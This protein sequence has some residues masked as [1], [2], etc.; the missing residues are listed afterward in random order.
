MPDGARPSLFRCLMGLV[1]VAAPAAAQEGAGAEAEQLVLAADPFETTDP[2]AAKP[3]EAELAFIGIYERARQGAYRDTGAVATEIQ[4][5][6]APRLEI[7]FGQLGAYG[8]LQTRGRPATSG[9]TGTDP[10]QGNGAGPA[11][12]GSTRLGF[13]YQITEERGAV[14]VISLLGRVLSVY[15][16]GTPS[17]EGEVAA[18]FG[19][20]LGSGA[21]AVGLNLNLGWTT[22]FAPLPGERPNQYS[23]TAAVGTGV[24]RD[25]VVV[26]SH[27]RRQQER[28][29]R[30]FSLVE[31]G[32]RHRF[33]DDW[34]ILGFAIGAGTTRDTPALLVSF[35]AQW[36]F[37]A[38]AR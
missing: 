32:V 4:L 18:L 6:V 17:H 2:L 25:T 16:P 28:G 10:S 12:G 1:L 31:V 33:A 9:A 37:G 38:G 21:R 7:R 19:K 22:R 29:E 35:A 13:L 5:G 8:N 11:W 26:L 27:A 30:D 3:G 23:F 20:T 15:G 34:P 24:S 14:P 36:S